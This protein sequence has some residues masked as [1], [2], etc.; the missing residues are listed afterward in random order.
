MKI[1]DLQIFMTYPVVVWLVAD[2]YWVAQFWWNHWN[3][4]CS[5]YVYLYLYQYWERK[6][7]EG[8]HEKEIWLSAAAADLI[9][10]FCWLSF[11]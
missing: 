8:K 6:V 10:I 9:H 5:T 7:P 1:C 2:R 3:N 4:P 11:F